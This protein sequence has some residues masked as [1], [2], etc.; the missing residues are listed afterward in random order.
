[1]YQD[2][3]FFD[4]QGVTIATIPTRVWQT[5]SEPHDKAYSMWGQPYVS[6]SEYLFP[7]S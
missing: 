7:I 2:L 3:I 1:M 6:W 5:D 4:I